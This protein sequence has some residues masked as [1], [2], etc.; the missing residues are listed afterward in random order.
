ME[1][2]LIYDGGAT[3][4]LTK[5]LENCTLVKQKVVEIQTAHGG[6]QMSTT[7]HCIKTYYFHDR[8]GEFRPIVVK[9][10]VVPGLKHDLLS[11]K[12]LN[13]SGYR[14]IHDED[15]EESGVF[16]VINKKIDKA[17]SVPF[18]S[19]HSIFFSLKLEQMSATQFEKQSGLG[20]ELWHRRLEHSSNR[21]IRDSIK[22]N[23][24]LEDLKGLT[25]V[26]HA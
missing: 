5:S 12:G 26:R 4:T 21:N 17:K 18:M 2:A 25:Y 24:G 10:Y 6:T 14:V 20:Y 8:L 7:H 11:V 16:A 3:S 9:A 22:W 1:D 23:N 13:Q 15:E 19:E